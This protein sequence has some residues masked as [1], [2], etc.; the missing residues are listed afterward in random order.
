MKIYREVEIESAEQASNMPLG[1][2]ARS[3]LGS[4]VTKTEDNTWTEN[5]IPDSSATD[6]GVVGHTALVPQRARLE[7]VEVPEYF[8]GVFGAH[9]V[10]PLERLVTYWKPLR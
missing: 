8:N 2:I 10:R 3:G 9:L 5:D 6:L 4:L 1:T 7:T